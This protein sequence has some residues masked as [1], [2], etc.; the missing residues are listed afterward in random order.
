MNKKPQENLH[1]SLIEL[2]AILAFFGVHLAFGRFLGL[3]EV[4]DTTEHIV[5]AAGLSVLC[6]FIA[7]ALC[8]RLFGTQQTA[9][10]RVAWMTL[11]D[12]GLLGLPLIAFLVSVTGPVILVMIGLLLLVCG[13]VYIDTRWQR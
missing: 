1:I 13:I 10:Y 5:T 8:V 12:M 6:A 7:A 11:F 2:M 3:Y 4:N 9:V